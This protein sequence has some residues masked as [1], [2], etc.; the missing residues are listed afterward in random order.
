MDGLDVVELYY[1]AARGLAGFFV[2]RTGDPQ[3]AID[4]V[5]ET[6]L[7]ALQQ[8]GACRATGDR[9]RIAW[10]Y[11]IA[12]RKLIDHYR[13]AATERRASNRLAGEL[14][15]AS[16]GELMVIRGLDDGAGREEQVRE[17]FTELSEEQR[18]AVQLRVLEE[19]PYS[20]LAR[21]LGISEPAARAR[22]SR[23]LRTLRRAINPDREATMSRRRDDF[24]DVPI[25]AE[26]GAVIERA[27][28]RAGAGDAR[29][30]ATPPHPRRA[31]T[32]GGARPVRSARARNIIGALAV[33]LSVGVTVA[34]VAIVISLGH[35][36]GPRPAIPGGSGGVPPDP[37]SAPGYDQVSQYI[38]KAQMATDRR[39]RGCLGFNSRPSGRSVIS[40][41]RPSQA[42]LDAFAIF[43]RP[44]QP[45]D[46]PPRGSVSGAGGTVRGIY[47][48][49]V[50]RA[51]Y[52]YGGGYY[53]IPAADVNAGTG[54]M[55]A[56]C[57]AEQATAFRQ[58]L[59]HIPPQLRHRATRLEAE[60]IAYQRY[61]QQHPSG[62]C[63]SHLNN[64]GGGGGSCGATLADTENH[65]G[66]G[67]SQ[68][69]SQSGSINAGIVPDGIASI[70]YRYAKTRHSRAFTIT[71]AVINNL[72]VYKTPRG[73]YNSNRVS[74][75][76]RAANG[77]VIRTLHVP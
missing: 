55:P 23:G 72:V 34:V 24:K 20:L 39:D 30:R 76:L 41:G 68:G 40:D 26:L 2:R 57:F 36:S 52:R 11:A 33:A 32:S 25:L 12:S 14:R 69:D 50:R 47:V 6:F 9:E 56:R 75:T 74:L 49:Y 21:E 51:Q 45:T 1:S 60:S 22:V 15:S 31:R 13:L 7:A 61:R 66:L 10:L 73:V 35:G 27:A 5:S 19:Q 58:E 62:I 64:H 37:S 77:T 16:D 28:V 54:R 29:V 42:M 65:P 63:L 59:P 48:H 70:T 18:T 67:L 44:Q 3:L 4:L 8:C 53:L 71:V 46:R 17:A 43:R 38:N